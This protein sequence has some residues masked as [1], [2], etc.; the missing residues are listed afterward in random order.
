[1]RPI[2]LDERLATVASLVPQGARVADIGC[3]HGCLICSLVESGQAAG[4]VACDLREGPLSQ[5]RHEIGRRNLEDRID[6]RQGDGLSCVLADEVDVVVLAGMGGEL[7]ASILERCGWES[8]DDKLFLLQ[9]MTRGAHLRR[10][11]CENGYEIVSETAC[12]AA[13]RPYTVM[14]VRHTGR[15]LP[16][17]QYD[18]YAFI[19]ELPKN[20]SPAARAYARRVVTAL[21][22]RETGVLGANPQEAAQLRALSNKLIAMTESW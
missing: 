18:L 16:L 9:P 1:M 12:I 2:H 8:M 22:R 21:C 10:W 13:R 14:C 7:I 11:L 5:A 20:P 17:S 6:L 3:D 19:G 15:V 4:G